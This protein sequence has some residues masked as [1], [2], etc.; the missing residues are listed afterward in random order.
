MKQKAPVR[1]ANGRLF[2]GVRITPSDCS[3]IDGRCGENG[4]DAA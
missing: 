3:K 4:L 1:D 2:C